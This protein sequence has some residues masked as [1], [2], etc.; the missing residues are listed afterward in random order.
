MISTVL[1]EPVRQAEELIR[2]AERTPTLEHAQQI[3][4]DLI[5]HGDAL[6]EGQYVVQLTR[7]ADLTVD[8]PVGLRQAQAEDV[9][10]QAV[11]AYE[12]R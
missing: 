7:A 11:Q 1:T 9:L 2:D 4:K 8:G 5:D 10:R 6:T 12:G 3:L